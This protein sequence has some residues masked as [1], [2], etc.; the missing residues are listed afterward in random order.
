MAAHNLVEQH[1]EP[2]TEDIVVASHGFDAALPRVSKD[3]GETPQHSAVSGDALAKDV[4]MP[5]VS[6]A[7]FLDEDF[8]D[9]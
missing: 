1:I 8:V 4:D 6:H 3:T 7:S 5:D 2:N 9:T